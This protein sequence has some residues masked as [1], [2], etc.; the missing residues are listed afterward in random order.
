[1]Y[2]PLNSDEVTYDDTKPFARA[3]AELLE[4]QHPKQ[5]VSRMTKSLRGGK[6]LIDWSQNDEHK[7]TVVRVLAAREGAPH[8]VDAG[9]LGRGR[10]GAR[11]AGPA[12]CSPS[13]TTRCWN[14]SSATAT[15]SRPVLAL[16]QA[17]PSL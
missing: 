8:G 16:R 11:G 2:V 1:M 13:S 4:K 9:H 5:V 17:L 15:C 6:V 3:V 12:R 14:A 7:T 10:G